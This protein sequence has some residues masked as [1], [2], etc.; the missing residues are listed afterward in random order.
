MQPTA[1]AVGKNAKIIP[2]PAGR[3]T[4][5]K[6]IWTIPFSIGEIFRFEEKAKRH[7]AKPDGV[8]HT[9]FS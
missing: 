5:W 6:R 3:K 9:N 7:S 8:A 2:A 1:Q 4:T